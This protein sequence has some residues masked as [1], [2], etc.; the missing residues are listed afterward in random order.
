VSYQSPDVDPVTGLDLGS[1]GASARAEFE[2][3]RSRD[4]RRR[5]E[6]F[7]RYL[8]PVVKLVAGERRSTSAWETGGR[9]EV[10]VGAYLSR[11]VAG[12]GLVLHDRAVPGTRANIDHI[13]VVPSGVWVIDTKQY[14][15][16]VQR[17]DLGGWFT[18][19]PALIVNGRDRTNLVPAVR[20]Q[21]ALVGRVVGPGMPVRGA[22][23]FEGAEWA[24]LGR[25]FR[26]DGVTV[27]RARRLARTLKEPGPLDVDAIAALA[28]RIA[29][30]FP[31]YP[32]RNPGPAGGAAGR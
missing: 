23:C 22:L 7:G 24:V 16:L 4:D 2:R 8:A 26:I 28:A 6:V 18:S 10:R 1:P 32:A 25:P 12:V 30:A 27:S 29:D 14:T 13:A 15:G 17:R 21:V 9:G 3:R 20:R 5:R 11:A 31:R 19:R